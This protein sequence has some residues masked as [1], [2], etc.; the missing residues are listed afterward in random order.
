[1]RRLLVIMGA[2]L[3]L[4]G[5]A[6]SSTGAAASCSFVASSAIL[7]TSDIHGAWSMDGC[8]AKTQVDAILQEHDANESWQTAE[9]NNGLGLCVHERPAAS[10][11]AACDPFYC[12]YAHIGSR[13][14]N[15]DQSDG[16]CAHWYRMV[17]RVYNPSGVLIASDNGPTHSHC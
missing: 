7:L 6:P 13:E 9:C 4:A 16:V 11:G 5:A 2:A 15:F 8:S 17:V 14:E 3:A 1:V 10:D 12:A